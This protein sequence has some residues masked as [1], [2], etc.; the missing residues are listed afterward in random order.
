M[1]YKMEREQNLTER[2]I[3]AI[4]RTLND[5]DNGTT[6]NAH[7]ASIKQV[8]YIQALER[9]VGLPITPEEELQQ[10]TKRQASERITELKR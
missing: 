6:S 2:Q 9:Q 1:R 10:L 8:R 7:L 3:G 4:R 5:K